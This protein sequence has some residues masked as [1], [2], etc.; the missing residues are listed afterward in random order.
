MEE[1]MMV[2]HL[3][4]TASLPKAALT[5]AMGCLLALAVVA[6]AMAEPKGDF[7]SFTKCPVGNPEVTFC[8]Y[9]LTSKGEFKIKGTKVPIKS[10]I[11]LQAGSILS[12]ETGAETFVEATGGETLS[13]TPQQVPGGLVGVI[14][15]SSLPKSLQEIINKLVTEGLDEV[16]ATAELVATPT[17]SRTNLL[18]QEGVALSLPVRIHL[19]NT[20]LGNEC[21]IG[22]KS[23]PVTFELTTGTTS[24]EKPNEP[25]TG[26]V[27]ELE[28]KDEFQLVIITG[29]KLV[30]N[31]Y[32]VPSATG[33]GGLL[34]LLVNPAVNL[35]LGL[36]SA[37][38]NNAAVLESTLKNATAAAVK[39]SE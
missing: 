15:V 27:G 19:S 22:S 1:R 30:D 14:E 20:F 34:S 37:D 29:N 5:L 6:P 26:V 2:D 28:F 38:G 17:I 23:A 39:A 16:T 36:P 18:F 7:A 31:A 8:F 9:G 3:R 12:E 25:I 21:Y 35:K 10:P 32:A 11:T 24:P 13:K 4:R 33:C